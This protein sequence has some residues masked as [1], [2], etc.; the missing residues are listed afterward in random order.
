MKKISCAS[1]LDIKQRNIF[2]KRDVFIYAIVAIFIFVLFFSFI[3]FPNTQAS[4]GFKASIDNQLA[5]TYFSSTKKISVESQF[6]DKLTIKNS[7]NGIT[8]TIAFDSDKN[9]IFI[10]TINNSIKMIESNCPS[11][12]C[13]H[14]KAVSDNGF[15]F[16]APRNI[17][18]TP[19]KD[20]SFMP[21][22]TGGIYE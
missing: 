6:K 4:S 16:C 11:Q 14:M 13:V 10:D 12:N 5:F 7:S 8:I 2:E 15:I 20:Q 19:I 21:P 17:M 9:V 18:I 3:I 1:A 22:T